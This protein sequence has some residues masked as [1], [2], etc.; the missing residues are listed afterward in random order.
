M[1]KNKTEEFNKKKEAINK[2]ATVSTGAS[3]LSSNKGDK[4]KAIKRKTITTNQDQTK[5]AFGKEALKLIIK[6][7]VHLGHYEAHPKMRP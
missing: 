4:K 5:V 1:N 3:N 6:A 2:K 7:G